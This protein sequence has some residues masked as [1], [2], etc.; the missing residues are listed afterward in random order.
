MR[1]RYIV[2]PVVALLLAV[3]ACTTG[4]VLTDK[5]A[6]QIRDLQIRDLPS[7]ATMQDDKKRAPPG[8]ERGAL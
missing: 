4:D 6:P 5:P 8:R 2:R 3:A 1:D 7:H